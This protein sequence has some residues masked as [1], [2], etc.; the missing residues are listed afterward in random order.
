MGKNY[1]K[2]QSDSLVS[3]LARKVR[4]GLGLRLSH[5]AGLGRGSLLPNMCNNMQ[6]LQNCHV[7]EA[8]IERSTLTLALVLVCAPIHALTLSQK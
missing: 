2:G 1:G 3:D 7:R 5:T 6:G 8:S 4:K